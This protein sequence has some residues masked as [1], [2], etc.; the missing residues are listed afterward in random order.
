VWPG[1][2]LA[3]ALVC[4]P[5]VPLLDDEPGIVEPEERRSGERLDGS[6]RGRDDSPPVHGGSRALHDR[7]TEATFRFALLAERP[8]RVLGGRLGGAERMRVEDGAR[9]VER[10]YRLDVLARPRCLPDLGPVQ[11]GRLGVYFATSMARLS[12]MTIT[13]TWP[14]YSS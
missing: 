11:C 5:D 2:E 1:T 3:A 8:R 12:R 13:L 14:G 6:V 4:R 9:C 7:H 10:A